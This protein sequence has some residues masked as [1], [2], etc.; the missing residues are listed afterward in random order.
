M[1]DAS[2][3]RT[4]A[5]FLLIALTLA[6]S[7]GCGTMLNMDGKERLDFGGSD[8]AVN[9]PYVPKYR[10]PIF[11]FGGISNDIAWI[12]T[13]NQPSDVIFSLIDMPLSFVGDIVTLPWTA[14]QCWI[15]VRPTA[16]DE[17]ASSLK[18][19]SSSTRSAGS[20]TSNEVQ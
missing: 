17:S 4:G 1:G 8:L 13:A 3:R 12:K 14:Y 9:A 6:A 10:R 2:M 19:S 15:V 11:P 5:T 16:R 18:S 20:N 7:S